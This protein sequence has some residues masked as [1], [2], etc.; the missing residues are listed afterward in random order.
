MLKRFNVFRASFS[1]SYRSFYHYDHGLFEPK[2]QSLWKK[3]FSK[4]SKAQPDTEKQKKY[5]LTMFPYPS[6]K[7]HMG[8]V[9]VYTYGDCLARF[10]RMQGCDVMFPIGWDSF[11]L[12]AENAARE[13]GLDPQNW[14][15]TNIKHMRE[16]LESLGFSFDWNR[17]ISTC[18][19]AYFRWTQ[20]LFLRMLHKGLAYQAD[21][22]VN[23]DPVDETVLANEQVDAEGKSWRSGALVEQK[24]LRQWFL[25]ITKYTPLL[26]KGLQDLETGWPKEVLKLQELWIGKSEGMYIDFGEIRVFTTKPETIFGVSFVAIAEDYPRADYW[27][28]K[29]VPHPL[30]GKQIPVH[31]CDYVF[32]DYGTG[33]V[34]GVPGNDER[35]AN[36]ARKKGIRI[37]SVVT[38][39]G[40]MTNSGE[41]YDGKSV[42]EV[43]ELVKQELE[44]SDYESVKRFPFFL[45]FCSRPKVRDL[46][47][48]RTN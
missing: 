15:N 5:I 46:S 45:M 40:L 8:H 9:R 38:E 14:T 31:I 20:W 4:S 17:E 25:R 10:H 44:V 41:K 36:F 7:L 11:G 26:L 28:G 12:P 47:R 29:T 32:A 23:W 3:E 37:I 39:D 27:R 30:T 35:D 16:Q 34:M 18:D 1:F 2:L 24:K 43:R 22:T 21:A 13:R 6:G 19:S 48:L 33:A 42:E